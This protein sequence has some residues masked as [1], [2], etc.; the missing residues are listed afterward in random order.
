V[1]KYTDFVDDGFKGWRQIR[2]YAEPSSQ[3]NTN[4][5]ELGKKGAP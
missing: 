1:T 2:N 4:S 5:Q 3:D